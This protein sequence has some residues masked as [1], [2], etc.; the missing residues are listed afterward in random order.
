MMSTNTKD[1]KRYRTN[2]IIDGIL[3]LVIFSMGAL[4]M[5]S[6]FCEIYWLS[7]VSIGVVDTYLFAILLVAAMRADTKNKTYSFDTKAI[8]LFPSRTGGVFVVLFCMLAIVSSFA[9]FFLSLEGTENFKPDIKEEIDALYF[10]LVTMTTVGYGDIAPTSESA[11]LY[12][13]GE[14]GS[15]FLLL[16]GVFPLLISRIS[17]FGSD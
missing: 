6:V 13:I 14:I 10:S 1:M 12:I 8:Y 3:I 2:R 9:G 7:W 11:R 17:D 5:L 16:F 4:G 15:G